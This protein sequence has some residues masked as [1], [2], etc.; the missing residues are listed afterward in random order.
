MVGR[1]LGRD[2]H[3]CTA[4]RQLGGARPLE[5][6]ATLDARGHHPFV[7]GLLLAAP[8]PG[9]AHTRTAPPAHLSEFTAANR[10]VAHALHLHRR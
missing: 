5:H 4:H 2:G 3:V 7:A 1:C 8:R 6:G 10:C 9:L